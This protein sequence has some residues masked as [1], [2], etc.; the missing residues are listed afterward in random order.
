MRPF[1]AIL[2]LALGSSALAPTYTV[3]RSVGDHDF[4]FEFRSA[5]TAAFLPPQDNA[6]STWQKLPFAWKFFGQPVDGYF[7]SDNGYITFDREAKASIAAASALPS[8]SAPRH[9]IFAFWTD[10]R[11]EPGHGQWANTVWTATLGAAPSRVHVIYWMSVVPAADTFSTAG[12]N[13]ALALHENGEFESIFASGR[14]ATVVKATIGASNADGKVA[15]MA[16]GPAF[17]FPAVGFGG[18]D[19]VSYKFKPTLSRPAS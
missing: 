5:A 13:F 17:D 15:V 7:I 6:L 18:A 14:K 12:F 1:L 11:M 19:D 8:A 10:L 9:S 2:S 4:L 16:E 3:T